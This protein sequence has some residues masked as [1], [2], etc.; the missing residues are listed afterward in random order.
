MTP[1]RIWS[2]WWVRGWGVMTLL[3]IAL[4]FVLKWFIWVPLAAVGFGSMEAIGLRKNAD[5]LPPLTQ[6]I[7]KYLPRWGAFLGIGAALGAAGAWWGSGHVIRG[8]LLGGLAGWLVAHFDA[9]F[10]HGVTR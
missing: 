1:T 7:A 6:V 2:R 4:I 3:L 10:D 8:A 5:A 9:T